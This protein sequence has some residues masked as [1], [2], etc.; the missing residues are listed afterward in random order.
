MEREYRG[1]EPD[2]QLSKYQ[3]LL[4]IAPQV[5]LKESQSGKSSKYIIQDGGTGSN[6][7]LE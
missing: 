6:P 3:E 1:I 4:N 2:K 7:S 5:S